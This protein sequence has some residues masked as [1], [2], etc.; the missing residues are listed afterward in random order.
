M[1]TGEGRGTRAPSQIPARP[2]A[3]GLRAGRGGDI[4]FITILFITINLHKF[5]IIVMR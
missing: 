1:P 3:C 5:A 4:L 2:S